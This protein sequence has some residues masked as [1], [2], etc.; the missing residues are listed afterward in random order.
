MLIKFTALG[1]RIAK[2]NASNFDVARIAEPLFLSDSLARLF[3]VPIRV[4]QMCK[5]F[6]VERSLPAVAVVR[7]PSVPDHEVSPLS[8]VFDYGF[9][10]Y[11]GCRS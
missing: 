2:S 6:P 4:Q 5:E 9:G 11:Q 8:C 3:L 1:L 10:L 7:D